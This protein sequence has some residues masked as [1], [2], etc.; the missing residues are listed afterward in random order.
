MTRGGQ[1]VWH[2]WVIGAVSLIWNGFAA[3]DFLMKNARDA[4]Y[5]ARLPPETVT[6]LDTMPV[7]AVGSW[8]LGV[9]SA[10]VGS[11]LLLVPLRFAVHAF[12]ASLVG[13]AAITVY[14]ATR[15]IPSGQ[16]AG[17]TV[18]IWVVAVLLLVYAMR[19]RKAGV[20]R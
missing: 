10:V 12:A 11:L 5:F 8:A 17:L 2:A 19:M 20:L 18:A 6:F 7:W 4:A 14:T 1:P 16:P 9:W 13:L 15:D 3:Y